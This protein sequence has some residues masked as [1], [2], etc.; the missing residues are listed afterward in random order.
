[1]QSSGQRW[2]MQTLVVGIG[3]AVAD[4]DVADADVA[5]STAVVPVNAVNAVANAGISVKTLPFVTSHCCGI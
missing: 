3:D 2:V 1:M 5:D 4:A